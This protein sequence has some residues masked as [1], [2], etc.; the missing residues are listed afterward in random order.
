MEKHLLFMENLTLE[1]RLIELG[2]QIRKIRIRRNMDQVMLA[3]RAGIGLSALK[4]LEGGHG[5]TLTTFIKTLRALGRADWLDT[6]APTVSM[7]C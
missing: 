3:Q 7:T 5:A 6:L 4:N 1:E 2:Y